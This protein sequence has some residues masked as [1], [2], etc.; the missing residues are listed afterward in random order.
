MRRWFCALIV[1]LAFGPGS[2]FAGQAAYPMGA[3]GGRVVAEPG[4]AGLVIRDLTPGAPGA[5]SGLRPGDVI[6]AAQGRVF[7]PMSDEPHI[8]TGPLEALGTAIDRAEGADGVLKL[9]VRRGDKDTTVTLRLAPRG[10]YGRNFPYGCEKSQSFYED[11]CAYLSA[12]LRTALARGTDK[13][14]PNVQNAMTG[15]AL[16]GHQSGRYDEPLGQ[17]A[18]AWAD[19]WTVDRLQEGRGLSSWGIYYTGI[20]LCEYYLHHP[21]LKLKEAIERIGAEMARRT[22]SLGRHGHDVETGY[23]GTGINAISTGFL[24]FWSTA[25]RCGADTYAFKDAWDRTWKHVKQCTGKDGYVAYVVNGVGRDESLRNGQTMLALYHAPF[26]PELMKDDPAYQEYK[27]RVVTH[28]SDKFPG[29]L[30]EA[31][32]VSTMGIVT[33]MAGLAANDR[34]GAY[35]KVMDAWKWWFALSWEP[36][37]SGKRS[38]GSSGSAWQ[39]GY[40]GGKNNVG[41]DFYLNGHRELDKPENDSPPM[42]ATIGI[43]LAASHERLSFYGGMP[44]IPGVNR[45]LI[46][47]RLDNAYQMIRAKKDAQAARTLS[48]AIENAKEPKEAGDAK[49]MLDFIDQRTLAPAFA[50]IEALIAEG[51]FHAAAKQMRLFEKDYRNIAGYEQK[52]ADLASKLETEEA[53]ALITTGAKY[54]VLARQAAQRPVAFEA[55]VKAFAEAQADNLYGKRAESLLVQLREGATDEERLRE[56]FRRQQIERLRGS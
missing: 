34:A 38:S 2:V 17:V 45:N 26:T 43:I 21:S 13:F 15:L 35:R 24:W 33:S 7:E 41:G 5:R 48:D 4:K 23:N 10:D 6:V 18:E 20:F 16:L 39:A 37:P 22:D 9:G 53:K 54:E 1:S 55:K 27:N 50:A 8:R 11:V 56:A 19:H 42:N 46:S 3:I 52:T 32:A 49:K 51:D 36:D 25:A 30:L 29:V 47:R 40:V 44:A 31:H 14:G 12:Q 28:I